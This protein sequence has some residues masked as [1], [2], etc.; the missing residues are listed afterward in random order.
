MDRIG[1]IP[2]RLKRIREER[3][4]ETRKGGREE[5]GKTLNA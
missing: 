5:V 3:S 1:S 4:R 2:R